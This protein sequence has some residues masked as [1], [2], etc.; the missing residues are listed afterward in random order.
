MYMPRSQTDSTRLTEQLSVN[1]GLAVLVDDADDDLP[2]TTEL[3]VLSGL[4][5]SLLDH[6][7]LVAAS[8]HSETFDVSMSTSVGR[9]K[10]YT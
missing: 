4:G 8:T 2:H 6:N 9:H 10:P 3:A 7:Q 1:S 5:W